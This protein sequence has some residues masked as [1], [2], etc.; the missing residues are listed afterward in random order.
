MVIIILIILIILV[1][2]CI[3]ILTDFGKAAS[4]NT[5]VNVGT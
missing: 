4:R 1:I 3:I 5:Y 2:I